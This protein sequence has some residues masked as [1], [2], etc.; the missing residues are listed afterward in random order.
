MEEIINIIG[1]KVVE[2]GIWK[3]VFACIFFGIV[4]FTKLIKKEKDWTDQIMMV[5]FVIMFVITA[6]FTLVGLVQ[7]IL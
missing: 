3:F 4:L 7:L 2:N 5:A 6:F 1:S